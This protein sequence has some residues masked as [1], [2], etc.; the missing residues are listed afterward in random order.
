MQRYIFYI[1]TTKILTFFKK[2]FYKTF[3]KKNKG[4]SMSVPLICGI[5]FIL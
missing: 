4:H 2:V 5:V 3:Y 1:K